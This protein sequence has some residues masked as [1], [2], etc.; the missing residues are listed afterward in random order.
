MRNNLNQGYAM[1]SKGAILYSVYQKIYTKHINEQIGRQ[2]D[3]LIYILKEVKPSGLA[4]LPTRTTENKTNKQA[5]TG[6][7]HYNHTFEEL[8][9]EVPVTPQNTQIL[10]QS[11][12]IP[13]DLRVGIYC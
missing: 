10:I 6:T 12:L 8:V 7:R 1:N 5:K 4:I 9:K 3:I 13:Q 11:S 2:T